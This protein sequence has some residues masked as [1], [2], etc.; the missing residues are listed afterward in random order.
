MLAL[1]VFAYFDVCFMP[2]GMFVLCLVYVFDLCYLLFCASSAFCSYDGSH[3]SNTLFC[4]NGF[5]LPDFFFPKGNPSKHLALVIN[6]RD[7]LEVAAASAVS[8][9]SIGSNLNLLVS[10]DRYTYVKIC[11][12]NTYAI[13]IYCSYYLPTFL[14]HAPCVFSSPCIMLVV[15]VTFIKL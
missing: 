15:C 4:H 12:L 2:H 1:H 6:G 14:C 9:C 10:Q 5:H 8:F 11:L 3:G 13:L 7:P